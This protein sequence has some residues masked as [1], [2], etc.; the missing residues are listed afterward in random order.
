MIK[1]LRISSIYPAFLKEINNTIDRTE[2]YNNILKTIFESKY[3]VSNFLSQE[4]SKKN[5]E[6]NEIIHN[7]S[8]IQNKWINEYGGTN[9]KKDILFEQIKF[10]D[11][12]V[13]FLGDLKIL[14]KLNIKTIKKVTN[15]KLVLCF[16]CAPFQK[17]NLKEPINADAFITCT[18]GYK[19]KIK[20]NFKKDVLLMKHAFKPSDNDNFEI[21]ETSRSIDVTFSGSLFLNHSLHLGRVKIIYDL[22]KK[23]KNNYIAV[24]F[25]KF[26]ILEFIFLILKSIIKLKFFKDLKVFYK[27][28]YIYLFCKKPIFGKNMHNVLKKTK[29]LVNKHIE[30]TE[31][32]GNMRL[33]ESTGLG[34]LLMT[35]KKK[36]LEK[37]FVLDKEVV[38]FENSDDLISKINIYLSNKEKLLEIAKNGQKKTLSSHNYKNRVKQLDIFIKERISNEDI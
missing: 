6:C 38:V 29:I 15:I 22:M 13:L 30:D 3:S 26:F 17:E 37:L 36:D 25:S 27:I 28:I 23:F 35:D 32:A 5:Y 20:K 31:Y 18:E 24:N 4:L 33:F 1:F 10:Y 34:C 19:Q 2:N 21:K 16:H 8:L 9:K 14:K 11:P 12:D 7:C